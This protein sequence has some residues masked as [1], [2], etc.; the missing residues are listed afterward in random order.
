MAELNLKLGT[1]IC[2][3]NR[4]RDSYERFGDK[5]LKRILTEAEEKHVT[6]ARPHMFQRLAGRFAAKEAAVK[7]LGTG[8]TGVGWK[9][10]EIVRERSGK[11]I[12][13]LHG[14]ALEVAKKLELTK[15]EVSVSHE[16]EYATA[17]VV[18]Y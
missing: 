13:V 2:S 15:F 6:S 11:P 7:A 3:V 16:R 12:L 10:V 8:W 1:D 9:E 5:L 18:A 17:T 14:R 4:I